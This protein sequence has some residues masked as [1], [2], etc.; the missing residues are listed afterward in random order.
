MIK[1][2][3]N[4]IAKTVLPKKFFHWAQSKILLPEL[5]DTIRATFPDIAFSHAELINRGTRHIIAVL[6]NELICRFPR[7]KHRRARLSTEI[8]LLNVLRQ[9][10]GVNLPTYVR[11][12]PDYSFAC[13][14]K[15]PGRELSPR[16]FQALDRPAQE[17][18]LLQSA[19]FLSVLHQTPKQFGVTNTLPGQTDRQYYSQQYF[20]ERRPL[21]TRKV[22]VDLIGALDIF[23][24]RFARIQPSGLWLVHNDFV[25]DH[26]LLDQSTNRLGVIDFEA[27]PGDAATD[28]AV[29]WS[30]ADWAAPFVYAHYSS[31]AKEPGLL[32][33]SRWYRARFAADE[34]WWWLTNWRR[35]APLQNLVFELGKQLGALELSDA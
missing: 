14:A 8:Q 3:L 33:R 13:Y 29:F 32:E 16:L 23:Y 2:H 15:I 27:V 20:S 1:K 21:M 31:K 19:Q 35:R 30:F 34:L 6:D 4:P 26:L 10:T 22:D 18:V 25:H 7:H 5:T 11:V 17:A 28:F 24:T 9:Q 12:A